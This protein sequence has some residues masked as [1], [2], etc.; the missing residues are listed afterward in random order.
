MC[1]HIHLFSLLYTYKCT[2]ILVCICA[3]KYISHLHTH[4]ERHTYI[5]IYIYHMYIYIH[6]IYI[7]IYIYILMFRQLKLTCRGMLHCTLSSNWPQLATI[8]DNGEEQKSTRRKEQKAP[9]NTSCPRAARPFSNIS[10]VLD[11]P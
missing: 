6:N 5:Y 4:R 7:Y 8:A 10:S 2:S 11:F 9:K 1:T 3:H